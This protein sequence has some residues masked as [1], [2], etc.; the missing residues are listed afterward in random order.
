M[1]YGTLTFY[2]HAFF[3]ID[4]PGGKRIL[5]D[6]WIEGNPACPITFSDLNRADLVLVTHDHFDHSADAGKIVRNTGA[7]LIALVETASRIMNDD[8]L[9]QDKVLFGGYGMNIG[10]TV[11]E[12]GVQVTMTHAF[13]SSATGSAA[14]YI[15]RL[16]D[17]V[18]VYHTGDTGLFGSMRTLAETHGID[19]ALLPIGSVFTM[20]PTQALSAV[21]LIQPK[22]VV[23]MHYG[24]FPIL[25]PDADGF[26]A[27]ARSKY[28]DV[29]VAA[30]KPGES[31]ELNL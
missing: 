28:P 21:G 13:H 9:P 7:T 27:Q 2:G 11:Q 15:V 19:V 22:M 18:T 31:V 4:T 17:G 10:G 16:E 30:L 5:I 1:A 6:P 20:D 12:A 24:T 29:R 26:A 14:G 8:G 3:A 23:P 25:T